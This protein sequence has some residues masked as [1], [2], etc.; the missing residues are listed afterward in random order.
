MAKLSIKC[1][2]CGVYTVEEKWL[3][4]EGRDLPRTPAGN[5]NNCEKA[6]GGEASDCQMC[7]GLCPDED[8]TEEGARRC[9][10]CGASETLPAESPSGMNRDIVVRRVTL[11]AGNLEDFKT[12]E[13]IITESNSCDYKV[14]SVAS[15]TPTPEERSELLDCY[16]VISALRREPTEPMNKVLSNAGEGILGGGGG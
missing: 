8:T 1:G 5:I 10:Q 4:P 16:L 13:G 12:F 14:I 11:R 7:K 2:S 9:P 15:A 6:H 3:L